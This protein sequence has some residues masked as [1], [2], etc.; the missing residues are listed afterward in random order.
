MTVGVLP[1]QVPPFTRRFHRRVDQR[2]G[3]EQHLDRVRVAPGRDGTAAHAGAVCLHG[4]D[5]AGIGNDRIGPPGGEFLSAR[6]AAGLADRRAALRRARRVQRAAATE[7]FALMVHRADFAAVCEHRRVTVE[8]DGVGLPGVPELGDEIREFV[9]KVIAFVVR[10]LLHMAIVLRSA[11]VAAGDTVPPDAPLGHV[12]E[13]VDQPGEQEGRVFGHGQRRDEAEMRGALGE[14]G[15]E[16]GRIEL[17]RAGGITEIGVVRAPERVGHHRRILD[18]DVIE[19][20]TLQPA[21]EVEE[22]IGHHP[23]RDVAAGP[24]R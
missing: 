24:D 12:V 23:A 21:G 10:R 9:R 11:I 7:V 22:Q 19:A 16:H 18:D 20:G 5:A 14:I 8:H 3:Q 6:R 15:D 4:L 1:Q 2:V 13:R 17:G